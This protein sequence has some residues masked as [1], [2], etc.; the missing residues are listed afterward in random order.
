[1]QEPVLIVDQRIMGIPV[2]ECGEPLVVLPQQPASP[3]L[4]NSPENRK[5]L[6]Y[7]PDFRLRCSVAE[8]LLA[9]QLSLGNGIRFLVKE[10]YRPLSVQSVYFTRHLQRTQIRLPTLGYEEAVVEASKYVAPPEVAPH[11]TGAAV[12]LTLIDSDG[13]ELHMGTAYDEDPA[14]CSA[15][16]F[17]EATNI[18]TVAQDN[19][20]RMIAALSSA[21]FANYPTEWWHWSYGDQY[22]SFVRGVS[23][24]MYGVIEAG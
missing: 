1:M 2:L 18:S 24:A 23:A 7:E 22:W 17:T 6:G 4:D 10:C 14:D 20:Q 13:N 11:P 16:C 5:H 21:G 3:V 19:R 9:A 15:A 8:R 12:D